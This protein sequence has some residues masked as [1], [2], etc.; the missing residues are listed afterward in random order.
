MGLYD[1]LKFFRSFLLLNVTLSSISIR[2]MLEGK[3]LVGL[4][5]LCLSGSL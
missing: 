1:I 2:M 3:G 4:F 5:D